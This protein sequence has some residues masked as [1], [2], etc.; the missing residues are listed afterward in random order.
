MNRCRC[1]CETQLALIAACFAITIE[2]FFFDSKVPPVPKL[3]HHLLENLMGRILKKTLS[4]KMAGRILNGYK[5]G[6]ACY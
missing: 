6:L 4:E 1:S 5:E 3:F 2:V